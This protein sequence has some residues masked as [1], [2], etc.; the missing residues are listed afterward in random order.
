MKILILIAALLATEPPKKKVVSAKRITQATAN[1][2]GTEP[3]GY[4]LAFLDGS[5]VKT[6]FGIYSCYNV[7]DTALFTFR[8]VAGTRDDSYGYYQMVNKCPHELR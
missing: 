6:S 7:G 1:F 2:W 4:Y 3:E 5:H 8:F